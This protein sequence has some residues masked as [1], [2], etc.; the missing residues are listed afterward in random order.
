MIDTGMGQD[1]EMAFL[2]AGGITSAWAAIP[3]FALVRLPVFAIYL[4]LAACGATLAG[5]GYGLIVG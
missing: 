5:W 2:V 3:V 1:A 4:V